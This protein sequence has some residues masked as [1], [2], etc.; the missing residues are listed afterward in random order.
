M[1]FEQAFA[2]M[3]ALARQLPTEQ[4]PLDRSCG[5]ILGTDVFADTDMPPFNKSAMDGF[6]C[7][8]TDLFVGAHL[9]IIEEIPA[10]AFPQKT[11]L[12]G[13]C[14][15]ILTG[16]PV[17]VGA[18]C[19][20]MQEQTRRIDQHVHILHDNTADNICQR[21]ED[22]THGDLVLNRGERILP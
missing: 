15:R 7:R 2:T 1:L 4:I 13:T 16:A 14:S 6:A 12:P 11:V 9:E 21:A 10:G 5:R 19:V 20:I 17:P 18:D 3:M 22:V 8:R